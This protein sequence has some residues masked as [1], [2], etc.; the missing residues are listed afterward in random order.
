VDPYDSE[1]V[2]DTPEEFS[3]FLKRDMVAAEEKIRISGA[4]LD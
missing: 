3:A 1:L 4:K 2:N